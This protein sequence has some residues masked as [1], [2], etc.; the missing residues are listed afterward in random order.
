VGGGAAVPEG[1]AELIYERSEGNPLF[2]VAVLQHMKERKFITQ[3]RGVVRLTLPLEEIDLCAPESL[4]QMIEIQ[5]ERLSSEEH[6]ALEVA[7]VTGVLFS[8]AVTATAANMAVE[9][10]EN[11]CEGLARRHQIVRSGD[12][13]EFPDG[14]AS[15]RYEFVHALYRDVLYRRQSPG[16]RAKLHL[17]VGERLEALYAQRLGEAAPELA[18]HFEQGRDWPRAIKYLQL[19]ADKAG[20]RF[21]PQRALEILEHALELK[22]RLP[23][24]E[25]A[26]HELTI[27]ERLATIHIAFVGVS[28]LLKKAWQLIVTNSQR[29]PKPLERVLELSAEFKDPL[30]RART[31]M[32]WSLCSVL[33][34]DWKGKQLEDSGRAIELIRQRANRLI[35]GSNLIDYSFVQFFSSEYRGAYQSAIEGL[36]AINQE[37]ENNPYLDDAFLHQFI[38]P[39][40]LLFLGEWG[41]ALREIDREASMM[42]R[43]VPYPQARANRLYR[44]FVRS[45]ALD[46]AGVLEICEPMLTLLESPSDVR[47]CSILTASA[48][49][50]LGNHERAHALLSAAQEHMERQ[51]V[52]LDWYRRILIESA[53][54]ELWLAKGDLAQARLEAESFLKIALATEERTWRTLAWEASA[55][56]AMAEL[57]L[58]RAQDCI[59]EGLSTMEGFE[60]PLASWRVHATAFELYQNSGDRGLAEHHRG[61]SRATIMK[62]ANSLPAEEPLRQ[63]FLSAHR[64][65]NILGESKI[66][67]PRAKRARRSDL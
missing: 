22:N 56:V 14:T 32:R 57:D 65:R 33:A 30:L 29:Y 25:R 61:L 67:V 10:L 2:M 8:T 34:G 35:L 48:E 13:Q 38:V 26:Q 21:E 1:L 36:A 37:S 44:A 62:L 18:H 3:E 42:D 63:R 20:G 27:L 64:V 49:L 6:L 43:N 12:P 15:E 59:A 24:A 52:V 45:F 23:A 51:S 54:T 66:A 28:A 17:H 60:V 31:V 7:S 9:S 41:E 46:F 5:V 53:F 11:L 39:W 19:A 58:T 40:S 47:F 50:N 4:R 16:R 55:R